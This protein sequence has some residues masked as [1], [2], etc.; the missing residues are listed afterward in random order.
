MGQGDKGIMDKT[1]K[2][3]NLKRTLQ[4]VTERE[5][6]I[7]FVKSDGPEKPY[8]QPVKEQEYT[9]SFS[10]PGRGLLFSTEA[11]RFALEENLG[12]IGESILYFARQR[13]E[14]YL[15]EAKKERQEQLDSLEKE[16]IDV[17][18]EIK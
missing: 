15:E 18:V 17:K 10:C 14:Q 8:R 13:I 1:E 9:I 3:E 2:Y 5:L 6:A 16:Q 12:K 11:V 4:E 7:V